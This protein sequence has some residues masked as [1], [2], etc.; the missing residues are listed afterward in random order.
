M[1]NDAE[2]EDPRLN[3]SGIKFWPVK[4]FYSEEFWKNIAVNVY[5]AAVIAVFSLTL[6]DVAR[7]IE[8]GVTPDIFVPIVLGILAIVAPPLAIALVYIIA[9]HKKASRQERRELIWVSGVIILFAVGGVS[10]VIVG[11]IRNL[12][13]S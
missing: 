10:W 12:I 13:G 1:T 6:L 9:V 7:R 8:A 4:W 3:V 11:S 2:S 5:S